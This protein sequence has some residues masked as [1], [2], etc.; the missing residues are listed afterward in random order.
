MALLEPGA[1]TPG[2]LLVIELA[3]VGHRVT[4]SCCWWWWWWCG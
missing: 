2:G 3:R 1:A 4:S